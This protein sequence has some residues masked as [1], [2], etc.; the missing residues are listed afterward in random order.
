MRCLFIV[1]ALLLA[2]PVAAAAQDHPVVVDAT[3]GYARFVDDAPR[4]YF[5]A[6]GVVRK[7]LTPRL[8]VGPEF[9]V[10]RRGAEHLAN[11]ALMLTGNVVYDAAPAQGSRRV[12]PFVAGGLGVFWNRESFPA[13][14]F[15]SSDP[16]FTA[17]AGIRARLADRIAV[18]GEYRFGWELHH[19]ITA[20]V[21][22]ELR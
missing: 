1:G 10:M 21:S 9:V 18:A 19:R 22:F 20:S 12:T 14:A 3:G 8:S 17:G 7:Y 5:V 15:W 2:G 11:L 16:A 6:A 13:G 4:H